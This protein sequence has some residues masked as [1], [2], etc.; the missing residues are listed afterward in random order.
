MSTNLG[1]PTTPAKGDAL[2]VL[3]RGGRWEIACSRSG[4]PVARRIPL[5]SVRA[6]RSKK[7]KP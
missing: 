1:W 4:V 7:W 2:A 3:Y 5:V 6:D